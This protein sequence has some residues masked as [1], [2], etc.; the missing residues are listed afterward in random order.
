MVNLVMIGCDFRTA[1]VA[2]RERL[3][4]DDAKLDRALDDL[5]ARYDCEAVIL[6]TCNRVEIYLARTP[7]LPVPDR[8]RLAVETGDWTDH[9]SFGA[10]A[11]PR[12][13]RINRET[14]ERLA[15]AEIGRASC[16]ERV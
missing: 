13:W 6:S 9:W 8:D 7:D 4:F 11:A 5:V 16:R 15:T 2:L 12:A 14:R 1:P 10:A 3:A